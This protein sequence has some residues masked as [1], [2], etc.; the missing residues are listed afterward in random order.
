[1]A[2]TVAYCVDCSVLVFEP[3]ELPYEVAVELPALMSYEFYA[4]CPVCKKP[5]G[6]RQV[7]DLSDL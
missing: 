4:N 1:M 2:Y 7:D 6:F 3:N 5:T